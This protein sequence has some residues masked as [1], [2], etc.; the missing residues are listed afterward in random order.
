MLCKKWKKL[1]LS[2]NTSLKPEG[3]KSE[4]KWR[5]IPFLHRISQKIANLFPKEK[6]KVPFYTPNIISKHL[7]H[8][9][10]SI[11]NTRKSGVC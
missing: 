1:A 6:F 5:K 11:E 8:N 10:D 2:L 7:S 9:K 3:S 4:L